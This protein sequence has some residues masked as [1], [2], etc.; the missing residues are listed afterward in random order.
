MRLLKLA[1]LVVGGTVLLVAVALI[2]VSGL[3]K[4]QGPAP[5]M[6]ASVVMTPVRCSITAGDVAFPTQE[7]F[8]AFIKSVAGGDDRQAQVEVAIAHGGFTVD[9]GDSCTLFRRQGGTAKIRLTSG[10]HAGH[11]A[12]L[13]VER[14]SGE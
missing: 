11:V 6:T 8:D 14:V 12:F 10:A 3:V 13:P 7:G 5:M 9:P 4:A 1:G 2:A